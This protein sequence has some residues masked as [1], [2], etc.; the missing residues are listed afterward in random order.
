MGF[1]LWLSE[2]DADGDD[3][4]P[5]LASTDPEIIHEFIRIIEKRLGL[6]THGQAPLRF[7]TPDG[8]RRSR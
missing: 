6:K 1:V 3:S 8:E 7:P 5:I 4:H 2:A